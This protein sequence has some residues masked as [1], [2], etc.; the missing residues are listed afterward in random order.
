MRY[1]NDKRQC[2][3]L[4]GLVEEFRGDF[5]SNVTLGIRSLVKFYKIVH[6]NANLSSVFSQCSLSDCLI[7]KTVTW[8]MHTLQV[9][10]IFISF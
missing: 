1:I 10:R 2:L 7:Y 9:K 5:E 3:I 8:F 4:K 6:L